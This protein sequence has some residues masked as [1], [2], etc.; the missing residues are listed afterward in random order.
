M[1]MPVSVAKGVE[2]RFRS[3]SLFFQT[4]AEIR[5]W[6]FLAAWAHRISGV[7]LVLYVWLH[8]VTLSTL[9]DPERFDAKM[10]IFGFVLFAFLEWFLALP[11]I[12][13]ALNGGR[14]ILF[15]LFENRKDEILLRWVSILGAGY[16]LLLALFM[17]SGDQ[18]VSPLFFWVY[19]I[20][21]SGVVA[22]V[23][24]GKLRT[25]GASLPW[26]LHRISGAFLL[27][28]VPAHML[29]MHLN[30]AVGHDSQIILARMDNLLIKLVDSV[31]V[32]AVLYHG[33]YGLYTI[34]QDYIVS[35]RA[36]IAVTVLLGGVT[37]F[38]AWTGLQLI[39]LI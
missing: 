8:I 24:V 15:E 1:K 7:L 13:H 25:S 18:A 3:W 39:V 32:V 2:G 12:Y 21:A 28:M 9:N 22:Y 23:A 16:T 19:T 38:M 27:L 11:V 20:A 30:P 33:A 14:L 17:L 6:P 35:P 4:Q 26:K 5:G 37:L 10:K 36:K 29:F 31:L 34:S